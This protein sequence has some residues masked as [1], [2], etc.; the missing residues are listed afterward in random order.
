MS[1]TLKDNG[2]DKTSEAEDR[3]LVEEQLR[4][5]NLMPFYESEPD[6]PYAPRVKGED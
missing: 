4:V 3:R 1:D 2:Q 5:Q 6:I